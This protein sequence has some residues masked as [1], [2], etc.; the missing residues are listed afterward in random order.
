MAFSGLELAKAIQSRRFIAPL[1]PWVEHMRVHEENL[2]EEVEPGRI[3]SIWTPGI[4]FTVPDGFVQGGLIT[5]I[6]D[7]G[8]ALAILTTQ[9]ELESWVTLDLHTRFARP[10]KAGERVQIESKILNKSKSSALVETTFYLA[11]NKLAAKV[12]GGWRCADGRRKIVTHR[13][14]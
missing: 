5:A 1:P 13:D 8:Q 4:Q 9:E 2:I 10:I 7:G 14:D 11:E 6:A 12:T 3:L